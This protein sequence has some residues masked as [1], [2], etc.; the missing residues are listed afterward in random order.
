MPRTPART[1]PNNSSDGC[2]VDDDWDRAP[3][4]TDN[5]PGI[6][7]PT[8]S[9]VDNDAF[10]D[11]CDPDIDADGV[12][13]AADICKGTPGP[14]T[15]RGC[16]LPDTSTPSTPTQT[17][18]ADGDGDG[19]A[20]ASDDCPSQA[21][22]TKNGCPL[23][24]VASLSAKAR[25]RSATVKVTASALATVRITV[26]RKKGS[27]W[28]RVARKT[29]GGSRATLKLSRLKRGTHRV[30]I[31]ISSSAGNGSSVSKTFRVR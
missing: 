30:R 16:P 2:Y 8:Q 20:D 10:G 29:V 1:K 15:N 18:P 23:P 12:L 26:E 13:N 19:V 25:K 4:A 9:N 21:V 31:S 7:N 14:A 28:V 24:Q 11:A 22:A 3:D 5:C 17:G 27:R 6:S